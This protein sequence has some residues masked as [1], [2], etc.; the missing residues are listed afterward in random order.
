MS[1]G[2]EKHS[3]YL[4][5]GAGVI[6]LLAASAPEAKATGQDLQQIQAQIR[7]CKR[8]SRRC[9]SRCR[10]RKAQAAAANAAAANA[11][12][13]DLD[14]KVKWKG[15]PE[16]SSADGKVQVE[17]PRAGRRRLQ[18]HRPGHAD[19]GWPDVSAAEI[20]R[21]RL[22]VEGVMCYDFKYIFEV[23]FANDAVS[24]KDAYLRIHGP[25]GCLGLSV[26]NFKTYNSLEHLNS[27]NNIT[28]MEAPRS[29]RR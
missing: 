21:A 8:L 9:R 29:S 11:G 28:F 12:S 5:A 25:G 20:R 18:R 14:L 6:G 1:G 26:G 10:T 16:L 3:R 24:V 15:A 27:A 17:G 23:D 2:L 4:L 22:G 13:G 19:H 7:K